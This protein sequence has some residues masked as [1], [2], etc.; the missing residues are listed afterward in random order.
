MPNV[1]RY[2]THIIFDNGRLTNGSKVPLRQV[3]QFIVLQPKLKI[4]AIQYNDGT[5]KSLP[6]NEH[7]NLIEWIHTWVTSNPSS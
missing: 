1:F 5:I 3:E 7:R 2:P 4:R 6:K